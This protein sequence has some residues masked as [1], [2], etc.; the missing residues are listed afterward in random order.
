MCI[1]PFR[2]VEVRS[3]G[4]CYPCC[5]GFTN[6]Y[7]FG[8]IFKTPFENIWYSEKAETFRE[9]I[10]NKT[11]C[12]CNLE[13]CNERISNKEKHE[14]RYRDGVLLFPDTILF[15]LDYSCNI[16]CIFCRDK[17]LMN[18]ESF[19]EKSMPLI[20]SCFIPM[21]KDASFLSASGSGEV[22]VSKLSRTII[23][24]GCAKYPDLNIGLITNGLLCDEKNFKELGILDRLA[25]VSMTI[26]ASTAETY[27]KIMKGGNWKKLMKNL[28]YLSGLKKSGLIKDVSIKMVVSSLNFREMKGFVELASKYD[29]LVSFW[30]M[31][32][33]NP[34]LEISP[35]YEN[36][37]VWKKTHPNYDDLVEILQDDIFNSK[38]CKLNPIL[39]GVKN[40]KQ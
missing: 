38:R 23:K 35:N 24:K 34:N 11:Y 3:T 7:S 14:N 17:V 13:M 6:K 33:W 39:L 5:P 30:P 36:F 2:Y 19:Y 9:S 12:F 1:K 22:L 16:R 32:N 31:Y 29:F 4:E 27:N 20:D 8:N 26:S 28:E 37:E 40:C 18:D 15:S 10:L 21:L 25:Y